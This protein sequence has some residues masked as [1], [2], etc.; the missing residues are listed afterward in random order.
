MNEFDL[1]DFNQPPLPTV[2]EMV[3]KIDS[4]VTNAGLEVCLNDFDL[5]GLT[6]GELI[7]VGVDELNA[8][9]VKACRAGAAFWAAQEAIKLSSTPGVLGN[10][11]ATAPGAVGNFKQWIDDNGLSERRVYEAIKI[12]KY[13]SRMPE[14]HRAKVLK[15]G[16]KQALLLAKMP[17]EIIDELAE[18]GTDVLNEAETRS[19]KELADLL[20]M[21]QTK[22]KNKDAEIQHL[23]SII[24]K[25][26]RSEPVYEFHPATH[27]VREEC[28]AYQA[29]VEVGLNSL[30]ALFEDVANEDVNAPEWRLRIEQVWVTAHVAAARAQA[31]L[32]KVLDAVPVDDLPG[33]ITTQQF[34]TDEEAARWLLDYPLIERKADAAK[35]EREFKRQ[36][37][38]PKKPGRPKGS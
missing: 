21:S 28:L 29:E 10:N 19:Y 27:A 38:A 2:S 4:P 24:D 16:K 37:A 6:V 5:M 8:S 35:H 34:L 3:N 7:T 26:R 18:S 31:M 33:E 9:M 17:Q 36:Q 11:S 30:Y 22:S 23:Q 15:I 13:Y 25:Q 32:G 1:D 14:N 20:R 12:A